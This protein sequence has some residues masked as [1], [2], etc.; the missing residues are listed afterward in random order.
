[1]FTRLLVH[2]G[3]A[4]QGRDNVLAKA[5]T[6]GNRLLRKEPAPQDLSDVFFHDRL[7]RLLPFP[8]E[9]GVKITQQLPGRLVVLAGDA[10]RHVA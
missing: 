7:D 5:L 3:N 8:F 6:V 10:Q 1:L 4:F 2:V 9:D